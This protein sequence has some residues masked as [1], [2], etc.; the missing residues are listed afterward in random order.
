MKLDFL[1]PE[2]T[3]RFSLEYEHWRRMWK[4]FSLVDF[5]S[6][7]KWYRGEGRHPQEAIDDCTQNMLLGKSM[8]TIGPSS[9]SKGSVHIDKVKTEREAKKPNL[10]DLF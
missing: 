10:E 4:A 6:E 5:I 9:I 8:D 1:L 7:R 3:V 2:N